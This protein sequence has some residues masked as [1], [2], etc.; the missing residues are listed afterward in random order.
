MYVPLDEHVAEPALLAGLESVDLLALDC[1]ERVAGDAAWE[2]QLFVLFNELAARRGGL[3]LAARPAA[4][5][6][7]FAMPDLASRAAGAVTYRLQ[8]L[9]DADRL[10]ALLAHAPRAGSSSSAARRS[11]CCIAWIATSSA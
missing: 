8:P 4:G 2:R 9:A 11:T 1:V 10:A 3:L 6:A 5:A 7:G